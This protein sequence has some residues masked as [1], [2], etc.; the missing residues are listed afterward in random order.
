MLLKKEFTE[1]VN[2]AGFAGGSNFCVGRSIIST[3]TS[4]FPPDM[5]EPAVRLVFDIQ[6]QNASRWQAVLS[7][8]SKIAFGVPTLNCLTLNEHICKV[9]TSEPERFI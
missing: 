9:R 8:S 1:W 2:H 7:I 5:R 6:G 4:K 3:T